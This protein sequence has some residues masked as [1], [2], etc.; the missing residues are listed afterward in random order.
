MI[1]GY[2]PYAPAVSLVINLSTK[3]AKELP[4]QQTGFGPDEGFQKCGAAM[5]RVEF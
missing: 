3:L 1:Q 5:K 4:A 2:F